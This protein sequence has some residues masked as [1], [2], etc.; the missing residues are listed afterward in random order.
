MNQNILIQAEQLLKELFDKPVCKDLSFVPPQQG[1][2]IIY[3]NRKPIYIGNSNNLKRR[4]RAHQ[5]GRDT[6]FT[7]QVHN[8]HGIEL[9][10]EMRAWVKKNC[11]FTYNEVD[12]FNECHLLEALA[13][14]NLRKKHKLLNATA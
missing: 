8:R 5:S 10:N 2:Y 9:G 6:A 7:T 12:D 1:V 14:T 13:I 3:K 11:K 4:I